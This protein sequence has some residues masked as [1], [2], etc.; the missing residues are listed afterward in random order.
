LKSLTDELL[1]ELSSERR[2]ELSFGLR[3]VGGQ[4]RCRQVNDTINEVEFILRSKNTEEGRTECI[5]IVEDEVVELAAYFNPCRKERIEDR[6]V[7]RRVDE[8]L[9]SAITR[10]STECRVSTRV[11]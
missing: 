4:A 2:R 6:V 5:E 11:G 10:Q 7:R 9:V 1:G 8:E 3:Q